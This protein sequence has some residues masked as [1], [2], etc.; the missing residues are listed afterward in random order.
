[1]IDISIVIP[2]YNEGTPLISL[3]KNIVDVLIQNDL[4]DFEIILVD[5]RS[6]DNTWQIM[7]ELAAREPL[8]KIARLSRNFGQHSALTAGLTLSKGK[9]IIMMD[10][11]GQD[12][13]EYIPAL[14]EAIR[15]KTVQIVYAKRK[16]RKDNFFKIASSRIINQVLQALSG[17]KHDAEI[18]TFR[19]M[20]KFVS[21]TYLSMPEKNRFIGGMFNWLNFDSDIVE[22]EHKNRASGKSN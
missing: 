21:D 17:N 3:C 20:T 6:R 1:M 5:D 4:P 13:P 11:D 15:Q 22:V 8:I 14:Y 18:G 12:S 9:Y 2:V 19:I 10:C 16:K 7:K